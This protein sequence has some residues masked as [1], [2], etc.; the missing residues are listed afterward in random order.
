[1]PGFHVD[2]P[3]D[4]LLVARAALESGKLTAAGVED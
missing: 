2:F 3:A 4:E 1:V